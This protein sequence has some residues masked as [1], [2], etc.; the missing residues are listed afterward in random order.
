M[1]E[2][3]IILYGHAGCPGTRAAQAYFASHGITYAYRDIGQDPS[4]VAEFR[5]LGLFATPILVLH[6]RRLLG[7]DPA[8]FERLCRLM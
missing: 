5:T 1:T 4:A 6:N 7:F 3:P 2:S 8:E